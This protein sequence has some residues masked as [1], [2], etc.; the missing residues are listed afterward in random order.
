MDGDNAVALI[1]ENSN[2]K[3]KGEKETGLFQYELTFRYANP[4]YKL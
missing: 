2:M 4:K 3:L 1:L